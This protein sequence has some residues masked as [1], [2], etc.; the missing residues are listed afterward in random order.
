MIRRPPRSTRTYTVFPS[1]T[2]FRS[3]L[4]D[5]NIRAERMGWLPSSPQ[6]ES[7]PLDICKAAEAEGRNPVD[8]ALEGLKSGTLKMSFEDPEIPENFPRNQIG[9][10]SCRARL[11][12]YV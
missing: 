4:I 6:L 2:L 10:A 12:Q 1:T 5:F 8:Y 11:C 3:T 7:N 9:R